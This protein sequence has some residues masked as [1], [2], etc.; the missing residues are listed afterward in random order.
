M[1]I[2]SRSERHQTRTAYPS[3]LV[4]SSPLT[5]CSSLTPLS[6][7]KCA[8]RASSVLASISS[9]HRRILVFI[10]FE[11]FFH[12]HIFVFLSVVVVCG[13]YFSL[14]IFFLLSVLPFCSQLSFHLNVLYF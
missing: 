14:D 12:L 9:T 11:I 2:R 5:L 6:L 8:C 13:R 3:F 1:I 4:T 10:S 7:M